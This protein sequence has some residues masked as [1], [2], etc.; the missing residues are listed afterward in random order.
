M[1]TRISLRRGWPRLLCLAI[2]TALSGLVLAPGT[3]IAAHPHPRVVSEQPDA[4]TAELVSTSG[5]PRPRP[6]ALATSNDRVYLGGVFEAIEDDSGVHNRANVASVNESTGQVL[7][8]AP[9]L[10]GAVD[11][12]VAQ[13]DSLYVGGRFTSVNGVSRR[14]LVKVNAV[15]GAVDQAF[16]ARLPGR[17][18]DL[19]IS[20]GM[21][22]ASGAFGANLLA[23]DLNTGANTGYVNLDISGEQPNAWGTTAV[24]QFAIDPAG[25]RLVGV[26]NFTTVGG[27]SRQRAF[28]LDL[29]AGS[30][31]VDPWYYAPLAKACA[32]VT[33]H[34]IAYLTDVDFAPDGSYFVLV[35]TGFVPRSGDLYET[36]CDAT[37]R[38]ETGIANPHRPTWINYTGG[39]TLTSVAA[40]GAAVYVQ[41]HN[42]WLDNPQG[43]DSAGPG[44]VNRLGIGAI[45][46]T[47]GKALPWDPPKPARNGGEGFLAT[48]NGLWVGS[49]SIKFAGKPHRGLAF[50]PLL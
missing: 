14:Y 6:D 33:P 5:V 29:N 39:D 10:N 11:A 42:R 46:P 25:S 37:A 40:T 4:D 20:R 9:E 15:T 30:A 43:R 50:V 18:H 41:G 31:T 21:L 13:G 22:F 48:P 49:D 2:I 19:A 7:P 47:T 1:R 3:A 26:G 17:V 35:S 28:M 12:L 8:F 34:M 16:N 27:Q 44:A 24:Y 45:D 36:I 23:L 32:I 38:F